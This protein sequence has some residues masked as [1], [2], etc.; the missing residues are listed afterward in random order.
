[1]RWSIAKLNAIINSSSV[2]ITDNPTTESGENSLLS[3][4]PVVVA[5]AIARVSGTSPVIE[6]VPVRQ[7]LK[8]NNAPM[9]SSFFTS[10]PPATHCGNEPLLNGA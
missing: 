7:A 5:S 3:D 6:V 8:H 1:M 9:T 2:A 4:S 10:L